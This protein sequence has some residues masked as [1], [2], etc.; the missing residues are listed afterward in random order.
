LPVLPFRRR[1]LG[2]EVQSRGLDHATPSGD[3]GPL[4]PAPSFTLV[5]PVWNTDPDALRAL[6]RSVRAQRYDR[7]EMSIVDDASTRPETRIV[8]DETATDPRVR[9]TRLDRNSGIGRAT[10]AALACA[11]GEWIAFVDH[12]DVLDPDALLDVVRLVREVPDLEM[13]Y[14]DQDRLRADGT[15]GDPAFKSAWSVDLLRSTNC[16]VHLCCYRRSLLDA[17]GGI[18]EGFDGSQDY[19]LL[20]RVSDALDT[21]RIGHVARPRYHWRASAGSVAGD[22]EAKPWA[23]EAAR[24]ALADSLQRRNMRGRIEPHDVLGWYHTRYEIV[25]R[26][27]ATV[28]LVGDAGS[29]LDTTRASLARAGDRAVTI[30]AT[31]EARTGAAAAAVAANASTDLVAFV[32]AGVVVRPGWLDA[33]GEHAQRADV[34]FAGG[35]LVDDT[36]G[37]TFGLVVGGP[38]SVA[39]ATPAVVPHDFAW[40]GKVVRNLSAVTLH[41]A[42]TRPEVV[43]SIG[44]DA[45][46]DGEVFAAD[47]GLR[48]RARGLAVVSTPHAEGTRS[49]RAARARAHSSRRAIRTLRARWDLDAAGD[50]FLNPNVPAPDRRIPRLAS[51]RR[52]AR[53]R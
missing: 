50:P 11:T 37:P 39:P 41:L 25:G 15:I 38:A 32:A 1:V 43:R 20:L 35:T 51:I 36:G 8:L 23:F 9:V 19:D 45:E 49:E 53:A 17:L 29:A 24:R 44:W 52:G 3:A 2:R 12:D 6:F 16:I 28:V 21:T 14:T 48:A 31:G 26:P 22:P 46:L 34:A 5:V 10:R 42:A 30:V 27:R 18:R 4:D 13:V 33:L 47:M 40:S 7:W